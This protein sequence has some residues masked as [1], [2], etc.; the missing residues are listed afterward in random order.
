M[1]MPCVYL[2]KLRSGPYHRA[3]Q[4]YRAARR[5]WLDQPNEPGVQTEY[6][7]AGQPYRFEWHLLIYIL[8]L[9][10]NCSRPSVNHLA[11]S[12]KQT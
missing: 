4:R 12:P 8:G 9:Q 11:P 1:S 10:G 6:Q 5:A 7:A 3:K 2:F